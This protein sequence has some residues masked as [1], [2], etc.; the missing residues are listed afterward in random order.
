MAILALVGTTSACSPPPQAPPGTEAGPEAAA[1]PLLSGLGELQ[2]FTTGLL[3]DGRNVKLRGLIRNPYPETVEGVRLIFRMLAGPPEDAR[4][5]DRF[6][7]VMEERL[8]S[9]AQTALRFDAQTMYAGQ[10]GLW[11]FDVQAFAIKRGNQLL[12][13]PPDWKE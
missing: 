8:A 3:T 11:W 7:R 2:V 9:G 4:V 13:V 1:V 6:Q 10:G 12:P 5:L